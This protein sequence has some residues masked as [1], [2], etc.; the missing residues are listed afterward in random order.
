MTRESFLISNSIQ[1]GSETHTTSHTMG[2]RGV[3]PKGIKCPGVK[4]TSNLHLMIRLIMRGG[5][6][7]LP[8]M[9]PW[10][11]QKKIYFSSYIHINTTIIS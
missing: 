7:S 11:A 10:C 6:P 8:Q 4:L 3:F 1:T 2:S 5:M 9:P